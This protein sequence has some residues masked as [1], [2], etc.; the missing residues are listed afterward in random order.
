MNSASGSVWFL[1]QSEEEESEMTEKK[2]EETPQL[3]QPRELLLAV[4]NQTQAAGFSG[5]STPAFRRAATAA[6]QNVRLLS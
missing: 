6:D 3:A 4:R 1:G 5:P 2:E